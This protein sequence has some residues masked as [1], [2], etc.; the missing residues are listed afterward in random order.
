[1]TIVPAI[2]CA[3]RL[4]RQVEA[5]LGFVKSQGRTYLVRQYTPHPFHITRVFRLTGDPTGMATLYMQ[6]SSGGLYGDDDLRL[7]VTVGARAAVHL[8]TQASSVV[9]HAR[10]GETRQTV[11]M[12]VGEGAMLE[13]CPD[14]A[15]LFTGA[16]LT[17]DLAVRLGVGARVVLTDSSLTHDPAGK[18][19][20]FDRLR[21][22]ISLTDQAGRPLVIDRA[23][24]AGTDW[25]LR[26]A[27]YAC[28]GMVLAAGLG[29]GADNAGAALRCALET[30]AGGEIYAGVSVLAGR[31]VAVA[32]VLARDGQALS[33]A[34]A[35][36]WTALRPVLT[37]TA[38]PA[39]PRRK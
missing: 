16:R 33:A 2:R 19:A 4:S 30:A 38:S 23:E 13:Y 17:T 34:L 35:D 12:D 25:A 1:M 37:G 32:R 26:C 14:P 31:G 6:S 29:D 9:H 15:I 3:G 8:T 20:P 7:R 28:Q 36:G 27:G 22:Q 5:R 10:G 11:S 39:P 21:T 18:N 24:V